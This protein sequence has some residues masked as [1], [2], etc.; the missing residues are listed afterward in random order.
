MARYQ[1]IKDYDFGAGKDYF[2][3]TEP[4]WAEVRAAWREISLRGRF[5]LLKPVDQ[6]QL[7][8]PFFEYAERLNDG[9]PFVRE[10]AR[11]FI[12]QTLRRSYLAPA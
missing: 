5:K 6:G 2:E 12:E 1:R 9:Q 10:D 4:F 7:F 11:A 3:K 8:V